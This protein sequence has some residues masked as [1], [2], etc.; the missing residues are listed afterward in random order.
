MLDCFD[1][2]ENGS[3]FHHESCSMGI[4]LKTRLVCE[5]ADI[6]EL[7]EEVAHEQIWCGESVAMGSIDE[8]IS[9]T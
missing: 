5:P 8:R 6:D 9:R 4:V 3:Q 1:N 2:K 7:L